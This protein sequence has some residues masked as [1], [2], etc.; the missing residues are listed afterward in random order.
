M[1][2][3]FKKNIFTK[4]DRPAVVT[5]MKNT[6]CNRNMIVV[7]SIKAANIKKALD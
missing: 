7:S 6:T 3:F 5:K 1:V 2:K 4:A